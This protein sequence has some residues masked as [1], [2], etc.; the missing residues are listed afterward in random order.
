M[1]LHQS[2]LTKNAVK[3]DRLKIKQKMPQGRFAT[4]NARG[5]FKL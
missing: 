1:D 5:T 4:K 2:S 3:T